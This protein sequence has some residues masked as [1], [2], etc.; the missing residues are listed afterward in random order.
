MLPEREL[1]VEPDPGALDALRRLILGKRV[2]VL[3]GAGV[4]TDSGIPDYR[5]PGRPPRRPIQHQEFVASEAWRR[6]YWARSVV[7]WPRFRRA[8]P[9]L[10][11][12]S[13]A[14]LE[15]HVEL[16]ALVT[17]NVD[18]L[19][20]RAGSS[21]VIELHGAL[22]E[23]RC[24]R[25]GALEARDGLQERLLA[26]NPV[27]GRMQ[28]EDAVDF[29]TRPDGDVELSGEAIERFVVAG[30]VG[31]GG[32]LMP[33][34]VFFGGSVEKPIVEAS[35][36]AVEGSDALLVLGTSLAVF[37]GYRFVKRA[38][39]RAIPVAI[40]NRGPTRGDPLATL[41]LDGA[42]AEILPAIAR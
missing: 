38:H 8:E 5:S 16:T 31:C 22:A 17:Q 19:H 18:R 32:V 20:Q 10:V 34:V 24:L 9:S 37:S 7:G 11:H 41:R 30:C 39:E 6:R 36:A 3:T 28:D 4:S 42:L 26:L 15:R 23:V 13:I 40:V 27:L 21:R 2:A 35:Y 1:C 29:E 33:N 25:C 14:A 12:R